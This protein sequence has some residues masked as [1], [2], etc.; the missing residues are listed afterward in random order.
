MIGWVMNIEL[1]D[2]ECSEHVLKC[3]I[4]TLPRET[5]KGN[6]NLMVSQTAYV[7]FNPTQIFFPY[8]S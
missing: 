6:N 5:V 8:L 2:A 7:G 3:I 1:E 4:T